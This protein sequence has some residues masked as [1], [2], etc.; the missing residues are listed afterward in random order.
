MP[1]IQDNNIDSYGEYINPEASSGDT[2][3]K[4]LWQA[5]SSLGMF[6]LGQAAIMTLFSKGKKATFT[7]LAKTARQSSVRGAAQYSTE[8]GY[9]L[10]AFLSCHQL[11]LQNH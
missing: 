7:S 6:V 4:G 10:T 11:I 8:Q 1:P 5:A 9:S 2:L 3:G